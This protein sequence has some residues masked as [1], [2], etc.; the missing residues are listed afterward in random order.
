M[1]QPAG[2][3][4]ARPRLEEI[5]REITAHPGSTRNGLEIGGLDIGRVEQREDGAVYFLESDTSF[6]TT[7]GWIYAPDRKPGGQRYFMSLNNV[8]GSWYEFEYGT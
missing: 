4:E 2:F 8:G 6:G 1:I 3:D 5:V 7:H